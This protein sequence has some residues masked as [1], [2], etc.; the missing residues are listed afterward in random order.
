MFYNVLTES[1][2]AH[3][4][5]QDVFGDQSHHFKH[6][7]IQP[8]AA[9]CD[10]IFAVGDWVLQEMR[11]LG[12]SWERANIDL[13]Y[14]GVPSHQITVEQKENARGRLQAYCANLMGYKPDYVFTHVTRLVPSKGLWRDI[15]VMEQLAPVLRKQGKDAVLFALST[16][17]PEGRPPKA[18]YEMEARYGWPVNHREATIRVDGQDIPDLVSHEIPFYRAVH[19]FNQHHSSASI[20]LVNQFG[21]SQERCGQRMPAD[22]AFP[23]IRQGSDLEFGQSIYEPFGIA[24]VEPLSFGALCVISNVCGCIGFLRQVGGLDKP[25][26]IVANYTDTGLP[27]DSIHA[28]LS[29]DRMRRDQ[30]ETTRAHAIAETIASRLPKTDQETSELLQQGHRLSQKMSWEIVARDY[31]IPGLERAL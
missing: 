21:W 9:H 8:A 10:N 17:I 31:M 19:E 18:I 11:Y 1:M 14:N 7:L 25:N 15:R 6:A 22:M 4:Y 5:L 26:V 29:I 23:D 24:Q 12:P 13:V 20:V 16:I 30:I 28:A 27:I 2:R 3:L